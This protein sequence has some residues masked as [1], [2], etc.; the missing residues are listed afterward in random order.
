MLVKHFDALS[1]LSEKCLFKTF[2]TISKEGIIN[3]ELTKKTKT[4]IYIYTKLQGCK[5]IF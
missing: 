5:I 3:T 4:N 2:T 1:F